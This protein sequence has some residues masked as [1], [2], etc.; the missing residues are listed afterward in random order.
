VEHR[1]QWHGIALDK[2]VQPALSHPV[3]VQGEQLAMWR[4]E[5][6]EGAAGAVQVWEDRCPHRGMRLSFG[7]VRDNVLHCIYH[8][9]GFDVSGQCVDIPA[10]PDVAPPKSIRANPYPIQCR[11]GIVWTNLERSEPAPLPDFAC[12]L[13]GWEPVRSLYVKASIERLTHT[14]KTFAFGAPAHTVRQQD[15]GLLLTLENGLDLM[16]ALQA[17]ADD[18]TGLHMT[19]RPQNDTSATLPAR[20]ALAKRLQRLRMSVELNTCKP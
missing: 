17:V 2:Q 9:W 4:G 13:D 14:L 19:A 10:H 11:Y 18:H 1:K 15:N 8:S 16:I 7:Y 6:Q 12:P 3:I 20:L 5:M